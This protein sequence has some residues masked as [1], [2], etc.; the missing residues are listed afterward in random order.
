MSHFHSYLFGKEDV[1]RVYKEMSKLKSK[2]QRSENENRLLYGY[3]QYLVA[4]AA[5]TSNGETYLAANDFVNATSVED[6]K[7]M[8]KKC[9]KSN[10]PKK[11]KGPAAKEEEKPVETQESA[12]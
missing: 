9:Q 10:K 8:I 11:Q 6:V 1:E 2:P 5:I 4:A 7:S 3:G 12:E